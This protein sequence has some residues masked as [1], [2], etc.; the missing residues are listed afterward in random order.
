MKR[1]RR[2][3]SGRWR[4]VIVPNDSERYSASD[5]ELDEYEIVGLSE[6]RLLRAWGYRELNPYGP[7]PVRPDQV[8]QLQPYSD[9]P[10]VMPPGTTGELS[11]NDTGGGE[12][13]RLD[14]EDQDAG[15]PCGRG[16]SSTW[17]C[18]RP[19]GSPPGARCP[20]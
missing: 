18:G 3:R 5:V 10:I 15:T 9:R 13:Q 2:R 6:R 16:R 11:N 4:L 14:Q 7:V 12:H 17:R 20:L 8:P 19:A 1:E